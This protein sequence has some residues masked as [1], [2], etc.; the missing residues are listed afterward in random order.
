[1]SSSLVL[2][3]LGVAAAA[4]L[5]LLVVGVLA[6]LASRGDRLDPDAFAADPF[7]TPLGSDVPP[8]LGTVGRL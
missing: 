6:V 2:I 5:M 8:D 3:V 7:D 4:V 1:M